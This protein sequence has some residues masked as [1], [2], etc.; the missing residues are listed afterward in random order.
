M[1]KK[2][3]L[4]TAFAAM[5]AVGANAQSAQG[6][7]GTQGLQSLRTVANNA[8]SAEIAG[9]HYSYEHPIGR[10]GTVVGRAG[11]NFFAALGTSNYWGVMPSVE[12]E[13]RWYYGLGRRAAK[14][15]S[16]ELNSGSFLSMRLRTYF[17]CG[18]ISD[19]DVALEGVTLAAPTWGFRRVWN[20]RWMFEFHTGVFVAYNHVE[21]V[22][23]FSPG[24]DLNV[25]FGMAF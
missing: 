2:V 18:Y 5:I 6:V 14:G 16:T 25:R 22:K 21:K 24:I 13:P 9:M 20:G 1:I 19:R 3:F 12:V 4:S 10:T 8:V 17:P 23:P 15:R 7:S 11:A